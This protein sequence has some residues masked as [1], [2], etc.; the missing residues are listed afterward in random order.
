MADERPALGGA[1]QAGRPATKITPTT[2]IAPE[3]FLGG[4]DCGEA[5]GR[6]TG[7]VR[8]WHAG[9]ADGLAT[10]RALALAEIDAAR[11]AEIEALDRA[12]SG[13]LATTPAYDELAER[14]GEHDRA[15]TQRR[16]LRERGLSS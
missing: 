7:E 4:Y 5:A 6:L 11:D 14:R 9:Y 2:D 13:W 1:S 10:G 16:I 3:S 15:E 12:L 8:G